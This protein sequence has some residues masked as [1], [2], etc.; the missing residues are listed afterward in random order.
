MNLAVQYGNDL[1][2]TK[3]HY[4]DHLKLRSQT[5]LLKKKFASPPFS[6]PCVNL[7]RDQLRIHLC[8]C[9]FAL[10]F[11]AIQ[12]YLT[13]LELSQSGR[14]GNCSTEDKPP[15]IPQAEKLGLP[16]MRSEG[17]ICK[18]SN[19][20]LLLLCCCLTST[21]NSYGHVRTVS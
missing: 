21:V 16:Y 18:H 4:K 20:A 8:L 13:N 6:T 14:W 2:M 7:V 12:D 19:Q 10:G 3:A 9:L 1:N 5:P 15:D 17:L 11:M